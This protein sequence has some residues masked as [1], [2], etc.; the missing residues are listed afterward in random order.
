ML[1]Y[2]SDYLVIDLESTPDDDSYELWTIHPVKPDNFDLSFSVQINGKIKRTSVEVR[3]IRN[4]DLVKYFSRGQFPPSKWIGKSL[5]LHWNISYNAVL[6]ALKIF[7][8][9][10]YWLKENKNDHSFKKIVD[11]IEMELDSWYINNNIDQPVE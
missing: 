11:S 3:M 8:D 6:Y 7:D 4:D 9:L 2:K 5:E 1:I 10:W